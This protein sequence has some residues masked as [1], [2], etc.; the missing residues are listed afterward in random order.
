MNDIK[1]GF[2]PTI[3]GIITGSVF[4][5]SGLGKLSNVA[6]FQAL[7]GDYGFASLYML[8]PLIVL[9]EIALGTALCL[10]VYRKYAAMLS[11]WMVLVFTM[12]YV[13]GRKT[14]GIV[15]CGCFG[16]IRMEISP[17]WVYLRNFVLL[18]FL[19]YLWTHESADWDIPQ[20]KRIIVWT[21]IIPTVFLAGRTSYLR[22]PRPLQHPFYGM[23]VH[24]TSLCQYAAQDK[25]KNIVTFMSPNCPHCLNSMANYALYKEK[26]WVDTSLC[27]ILVKPELH[28]D[29]LL[30]R[31]YINYPEICW[32]ALP[33]DSVSFVEVFPTTFF[34]ENDTIKKVLVGEIPAPLLL[35]GEK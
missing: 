26:G 29:T 14:Q 1:K 17:F 11:F 13:Y 9:A 6:L 22:V 28:Q 3:L 7:I 19:W 5:L 10:G 20:W 33:R 31:L 30:E 8:G 34:I 32:S 24:E 15:D 27:Y 25:T 12:V 35:L 21:V 2:V 16:N 18:S 23:S 4:L